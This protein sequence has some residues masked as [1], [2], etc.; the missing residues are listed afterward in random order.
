MR[1]APSGSSSATRHIRPAQVTAA[2]AADPDTGH[3]VSG[4]QRDVTIPGIGPVPFVA[5]GGDSTWLGYDPIKGRRLSRPGEAVAP[6]NFFTRTGLHVGDSTTV[7]LNG[8]TE[9]LTFVG[10]DLRPGSRERATTW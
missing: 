1:R 6:T 10:R 8:R 2:I 9:T 4:A 3:F 7:C 5:Y